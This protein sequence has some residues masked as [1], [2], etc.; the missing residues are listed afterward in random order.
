AGRWTWTRRSLPRSGTPACSVS[1]AMARK[2]RPSEGGLG[3]VD[4]QRLLAA[5]EGRCAIA[6]CG[7]QPRTRRFSIDH[8]H[9]TGRV[10]GLLCHVHNRRLWHGATAQE[11]RA[12]ADYLERA[13]TLT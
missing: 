5:Q 7:R 11:L 1:S 9:A 6:G 8:D 3:P 10:R 2:R 4:Y 13:E 12:M